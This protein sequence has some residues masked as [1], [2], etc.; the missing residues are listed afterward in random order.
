M[1]TGWT[2]KVTRTATSHTFNMTFRWSTSGRF[3]WICSVSIQA[4]R[5]QNQLLHNDVSTYP[6][7]STDTSKWAVHHHD[8][9]ANLMTL[10]FNGKVCHAYRCRRSSWATVL[11]FVS[12]FQRAWTNFCY[13]L[14]LQRTPSPAYFLVIL[15]CPVNGLHLRYSLGCESDK[16]LKSTSFGLLTVKSTFV[17]RFLTE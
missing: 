16:K 2:D 3:S 10:Q 6:F 8:I 13:T 17:A 7:V 15:M 9:C 14:F 12:P 4:F 11:P 1:M 5:I